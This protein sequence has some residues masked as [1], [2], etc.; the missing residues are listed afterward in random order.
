MT[1]DV[2]LD[3]VSMYTPDYDRA[4]AIRLFGQFRKNSLQNSEEVDAFIKS[5]LPVEGLI[6]LRSVLADYG[7]VSPNEMDKAAR[8][9]RANHETVSETLVGPC[10]TEDAANTLCRFLQSAIPVFP[11]FEVF[12]T[13]LEIP[14]TPPMHADFQCKY[15][16]R[17]LKTS[18]HPF[19][20]DT[21]FWTG[22]PSDLW[23]IF[24]NWYMGYTMLEPSNLEGFFSVKECADYL[25][26]K[27]AKLLSWLETHEESY[28]L[29]RGR[30]LIPVDAAN[31]LKARWQKN[32]PVMELLTP[33]LTQFPAKLRYK[34]KTEVFEHIHRYKPIWIL[35]KDALPQ[36]EAIPYTDNPLL[37]DQGLDEIVNRIPALPLNCLTTITGMSLPLLRKKTICGALD[38]QEDEK[39]SWNISVNERNRVQALHHQYIALE[40]IVLELRKSMISKF[41]A[42][43]AYHRENLLGF[44]QGN[45]WWGLDYV[46]CR[47][48]PM[49]GKKFEI[50]IFREDD[51]ILRKHIR[52]W[53]QGYQQ[54]P[55]EKF[56]IITED[57]SCQ[58]P[59]TV[60]HLLKYEKE[61]HEADS[62][63]VDMAQ[64][65][66]ISLRKELHDMDANEI[67]HALVA[68][69]SK[70]ATVAA[71][72]L[73][74]DFLLF[75]KYTKRRFR[76]SGTGIKVDTSAY[77]VKD[78]AVMVSHVVNEEIISHTDL[79]NKAV[80]NKKY[81]DLWLYVALHVYASWRSTDYIRM[82]AP[83]LP[84]T[85]E[86]ILEKCR[87]GSFS[88]KDAIGI[89]EYFIAANCLLLNVPNKTKGT[90][91]V[92]R[93]YFFCPQ[94]CLESFGRILAIATAHHQLSS[95]EGAFVTPVKD[96]VTIR[97]FFG[98]WFLE[99]C[100]NRPFSGRRANKAL[101]QSIEYIGRE[102]NQLPPMVAYHLASVM[103]SH[104]LSY[105]KTAETTDIYLRD[106]SFSGHTPEYIIYQMWERGVCSF[107]VDAMLGICYGEQYARLSVAQ[108]T[109]AICTLGL[110]PANTADILRCIQDSMD[111][112][113]QTIAEV[114]QDKGT[115]ST[116]LREIAMG[117]GTGKDRDVFCVWKAAG[118]PCSDKARL[119]CMGCRYEIRTK[120]LLLRYATN[121]RILAS[122][123]EAM[124]EADMARKKYL[125]TQVTWPAMT[126]IFA[127]LASVTNAEEST[128]YKNLIEE[129]ICYGIDSSCAS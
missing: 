44:C 2:F 70:N 93:L 105:G 1:I 97:Q 31:K 84:D 35:S 24:S 125:F 91:G 38:A 60:K 20:T 27:P 83:H 124:S 76:F 73:L 23:D 56:R 5:Y 113:C 51:P 12:C 54:A 4:T 21:F 42:R 62:A 121:H 59:K 95:K 86:I 89:A 115:L 116:A 126:E 18:Y 43:I 119:S 98:D 112:A 30:C 53:M 39:G 82:V 22:D 63:L 61:I 32:H 128:L 103:R 74:A 50:A 37:A 3:Q 81:A 87:N 65:L 102:E 101:L 33:K 40:D 118:K 108:Q 67:E 11:E 117:H 68:R 28:I 36:Q 107:V 127:H 46:D 66:L 75:G 100:G 58:Y 19:L 6:P 104:K 16:S 64:L 122:S 17:L 10:V 26:V 110:S 48:L 14:A 85:P 25:E 47:E 99:A 88:A 78:F 94:S 129:A 29:Y 109:K 52:L 72:K 92:P 90:S 111:Q 71:C 120:A 114:S 69:F 7:N 106:A 41:D 8:W 79:V 9:L 80:A 57:F 34:V 55:R 123:S 13:D 45:D 77:P 96:W 49:D 15:R